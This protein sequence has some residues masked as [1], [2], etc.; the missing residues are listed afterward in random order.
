MLL[1]MSSW[2]SPTL[3]TCTITFLFTDVEGSTRLWEEHSQ[4]MR[5]VMARHDALL[6]QVFERHDGVVVRPRGEGDSL[7]AVFVRVSD[8]VAAALAGQRALAAEDWGEI[9]LLR[10]RMGLH[11]GEADLREGDYYGS[12]VNR[13]ARLRSAGHGGQI[14]LSEATA[15]LVRGT[16]PQ[17]V[18]LV[19]LGRHRLKDLSEAEPIFQL[20][21]PDLPDAFPPLATLDA[22][23]NNLPFQLTSFIGREQELSDL[24]HLLGA[25]RLITLTGPGGSGKTRL[26]LQVAAQMLDAFPDGVW[27]VDLFGVLD[28]VGVIPA[29]AQ[30]LTVRES[31]GRSLAVSLAAYLR[32]KR[33]LLLLD[34]FEQ[35]V[36]AAPQLYELLTAALG[37]TI[38]VT[39]RV[40]LRVGGEHVYTL[41]PL[42]LPDLAG[43]AAPE[44]VR[45]NPAVQLFVARAQ[46]L[47]PDFALTADNAIA[48]ATICTRLD[49]LPLSIELA[50]ARVRLLPPRA[51]LE[52]LDQRLPLLTGGERERPRRQ[53]TLRDTLQWSWELLEP[54]EQALFRRLGVFASGWTLAAA[55]A[56]CDRAGEL[57]L[58][59]GLT[60]LVDNSLVHQRGLDGETRFGMLATL[61]EFALEQLEASGEAA[62]LRR[63]HAEYYTDLVERAAATYRRTGCAL[64]LLRALDPEHDEFS[65]ALECLAEQQ[66][67]ALGLRL[68]GSLGTWFLMRALGEGQR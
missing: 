4:A 3:P 48:I 65:A 42:P 64:D 30:V 20:R 6:T 27:F 14:L 9:G 36:A 2:P 19:D 39:S 47:E 24:V 63:H 37:P 33:L 34:N 7:F 60:S 32:R 38:L 59:E 5:Q 61:R 35:V 12:A 26:A 62:A 29:I 58:L 49:G 46:A 41:Q 17:H 50:A 40:L 66:D 56:I 13:C 18:P 11:T 52:R 21:A 45:H 31:E 44:R 1:A 25:A 67:A 8:A 53:Q 68:A 15:V 55:A 23:P 54:A 22:H 57:D 51:L 16:V 43:D 28:A 10:V